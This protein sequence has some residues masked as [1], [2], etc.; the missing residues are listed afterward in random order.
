MIPWANIWNT[1]PL[2]PDFVLRRG[3]LAAAATYWPEGDLREVLALFSTWAA[4]PQVRGLHSQTARALA[5]SLRRLPAY[6]DAAGL[7]PG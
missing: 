2:S 4:H 3:Y 1:E 6:A 7:C 5:E